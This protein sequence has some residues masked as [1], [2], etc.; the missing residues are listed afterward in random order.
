MS[1]IAKLLRLA[2]LADKE[3]KTQVVRTAA[4][5]SGEIFTSALTSQYTRK[6][7]FA[8]N[9]T[10]SASG[11]V[12]YGPSGV[13]PDDGMLLPKAEVTEIMLASSLDLYFVATSG[14]IE[15]RVVELA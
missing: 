7:L 12:Y 3:I 13:T 4:Q 14:G 5:I 10:D 9:A 1:E 15:I 11:E 2:S 6:R 8:Y